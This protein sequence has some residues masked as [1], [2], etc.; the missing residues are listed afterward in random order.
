MRAVR[1]L[2]AQVHLDIGG[3]QRATVF[4][5]G[6]GRG[7]TTWIAEIINHD[8][9]YRFIFEPFAA[10]HVPMCRAFSNRQYLRTGDT[11]PE[12]VEPAKAIVSGKIRN[13]WT[14]FYNRRLISKRRLIKDIRAGL[15]LRWLSDLSPGMPIV[16]VLRHP[17]AVA[18]S[19]VRYS[20]GFDMSE[21]LG[22]SQ[23]VADYLSPLRD[24][25]AAISDPFEAH[26]ARWC[27]ENMVPV[28]QF[29]KGEIHVAFYESFRSDPR[30]EVSRLFEFLQRPL[31][32]AVFAHIARPSSMAWES[33]GGIK[34]GGSRSD[35]WRSLITNAQAG[36]ALD[37]LKWF[38]LDR[39]Y[40]LD[41]APLVSP[42][43]VL[44][45][46]VIRPKDSPLTP[47]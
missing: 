17:C 47:H 18:A 9:K 36:R 39:I 21:F 14:D 45:H 6:S 11:R 28:R 25:L 3:D 10:L 42:E 30:R 20:W 5:A 33:A 44:P 31:D 8:N 26:V 12:F 7:G 32:D 41:P 15:F 40:G 24:R 38:D 13:G 1:A 35:G 16:L 37:I 46:R 22:Q 27:I 34:Q 19:R 2:A 23:L 29:C 43:A 4:L